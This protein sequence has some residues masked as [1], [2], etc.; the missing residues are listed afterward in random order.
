ASDAIRRKYSDVT[1]F[2]VLDID[3]CNGGWLCRN[4]KHKDKFEA[5]HHSV[6]VPWRSYFV[7]WASCRP[8]LAPRKEARSRWISIVTYY[9][10]SLTTVSTATG[11]T[12]ADA[13]PICGSTKRK[14]YLP[15][16]AAITL[17]CQ[18]NRRRASCTRRS[19]RKM[20]PSGCL[21][22]LPIVP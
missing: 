15:T 1:I 18:G 3:L 22:P 4:N 10:F 9:R 14:V 17:C 12:K 16:G 20:R 19:A 11:Q 6:S 7:L 8:R 5:C 2:A 21:Q 13:K